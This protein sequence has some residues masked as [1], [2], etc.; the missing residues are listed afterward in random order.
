MTSTPLP[1]PQLEVIEHHRKVPDYLEP[2]SLGNHPGG[3][4][5]PRP[6]PSAGR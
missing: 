4:S 2:T 5:P 1:P 3:P 6:R